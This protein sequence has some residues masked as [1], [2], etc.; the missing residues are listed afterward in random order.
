MGC[1]GVSAPGSRY[2]LYVDETGDRGIARFQPTFPV[3]GLC[4]CIVE[5]EAYHGVVVPALNAFKE[6]WFGDASITLHYSSIMKRSG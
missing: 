1:V 6:S 3:L 5:D 4:G 2:T